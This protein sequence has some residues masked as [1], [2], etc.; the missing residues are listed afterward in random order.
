MKLD[1]WA[2]KNPIFQTQ[3][4]DSRLDLSTFDKS[5]DDLKN[6]TTISKLAYYTGIAAK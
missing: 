4:T 2:K 1:Y 6:A 3:W 5:S